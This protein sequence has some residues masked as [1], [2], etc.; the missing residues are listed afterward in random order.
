MPGNL[1]YKVAN[2]KLW[3][4]A[5]DHSPQ[6]LSCYCVEIPRYH[7]KVYMVYYVEL[8]FFFFLS[9]F[10]WIFPCI[11][12][13]FVLFRMT[14]VSFAFSHTRIV[15]AHFLNCQ[16]GRE[17]KKKKRTFHLFLLMPANLDVLRVKLTQTS[18]DLVKHFFRGL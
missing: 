17:G 9:G 2:D 16:K 3:M 13:F 4:S 14:S 1:Q 11:G 8:F 7:Y 12:L 18:S 15:G 5:T 10:C 6:F